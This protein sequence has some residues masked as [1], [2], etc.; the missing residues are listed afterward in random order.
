MEGGLV[1]NE[2]ISRENQQPYERMDW[3]E[4]NHEI[5]GDLHYD[6]WDQWTYEHMFCQLQCYMVVV[7]KW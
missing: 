5:V 4:C 3:Y 7:Y 6:Q 1:E 2:P